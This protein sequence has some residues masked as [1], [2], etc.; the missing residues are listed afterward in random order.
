PLRLAKY[1]VPL[2]D[3]APAGLAAAGIEPA[4]LPPAPAQVAAGETQP[5]LPS[6]PDR[7]HEQH[8]QQQQHE[9]PYA[10]Q[11]QHTQQYEQPYA[12][13]HPQQHPQQ[14]YQQQQLQQHPQQEN[15]GAQGNPWFTASRVSNET[16][17]GTYD[18][19]YV[20]GPEPGPVMVPSGPG[21]RT[22]PLGNVGT[23]GAGP[24]T[25]E[26][27][28][29]EQAHPAQDH[30]P[31]QSH[32]AQEPVQEQFEEH[33]EE[34]FEEQFQEPVQ[35]QFQEQRAERPRAPEQDAAEWAQEDAE[36]AEIAYKEFAA[37][38]NQNNDFPSVD[39]LDIHVTDVHNVRHPRSAA[40]LRRMMPEFK[41]RY[42]AE[43]EADH[44]A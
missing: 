22:R 37:F 42:H 21:G 35:E 40:L 38:V 8:E 32:P 14:Q 13:D 29:D 23:I 10:Q 25:A 28:P 2:A 41:N 3:T 43:L 33:F 31:A 16:Y 9:Q 44:I 11:Q 19:D 6:A 30:R 34:H 15:P 4:L 18:P 5:E 27:R 17:E 7:Q 24:R 26:H 20:E 1:G 36:F 39:A 12:P